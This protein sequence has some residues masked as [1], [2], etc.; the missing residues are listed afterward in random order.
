MKAFSSDANYSSGPDVGTPTK[1]APAFTNFIKDVP[2]GAQNINSMFNTRDRM[3]QLA[4]ANCAQNWTTRELAASFG[5][6]S[7][8]SA[9]YLVDGHGNQTY[10]KWLVAACDSSGAGNA[11]A[12]TTEGLADGDIQD[13]SL[14]PISSGIIRA[15]TFN[16]STAD[17]LAFFA[18]SGGGG[19]IYKCPQGG[20]WTSLISIGTAIVG[21]PRLR[22][23]GSSIYAVYITGGNVVCAVSSNNG[24]T[25]G[26]G[27]T[28]ATSDTT[29]DAADNGSV[30]MVMSSS[31]AYHVGSLASWSSF[32]SPFG[33][34]HAA[35]A[36]CWSPGIGA[37]FASV[38]DGV[39]T[40]IW[41]SDDNVG[42]S[43]VSGNIPFATFGIAAAG[44]MLA[45]SDSTN[46]T[47]GAYFSPD[48][49]VTWYTAIA[50]ATSPGSPIVA[51]AVYGGSVGFCNLGQNT[52]RFSKRCGLPAAQFP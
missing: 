38:Y 41:R 7:A 22:Y 35:T 40:T 49:G 14:S 32:A 36:I 21:F 46:T 29:L 43:Q 24:V 4:L 10:A 37:W 34:G 12:F 48:E 18:P 17:Y 6:L 26:N 31:G 27:F 39:N 42:W 28:A 11:S 52:L 15:L 5:G 51:P 9:A 50:S 47:N 2:F 25:W 23:V 16:Q 13:V 30:V 19:V 33:G 1:V 45:I 44:Q 3:L 8:L 20:S